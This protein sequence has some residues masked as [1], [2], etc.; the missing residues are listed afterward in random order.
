MLSWCEMAKNRKKGGKSAEDSKTDA[1]IDSMGNDAPQTTAAKSPAP[2]AKPKTAAERRKSK[3]D[4]I[5]KTVYP[6]VLGVAGGFVC[7]Y[8]ADVINQ[9]PWHFVTIMFIGLTL[10]IQKATYPF[11]DIDVNEFRGKDWFYVEFMAVDLW[12][13]SWTFLLN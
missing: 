4:A 11:M 3:I 6:A 5:K 10:F 13:V 1:K 8:G 9:L 7:F 2:K 12:L